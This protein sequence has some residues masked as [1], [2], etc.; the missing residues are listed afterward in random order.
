MDQDTQKAYKALVVG[1]KY[2][3]KKTINKFKKIKLPVKV[4]LVDEPTNKHDPNAIK[5][6]MGKT[7]MGYIS[8]HHTEKIHKN[9]DKIKKYELVEGPNDMMPFVRMPI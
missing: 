4:E 3:P 2:R 9:K 8:K 7:F 6:M 1:L 5:V